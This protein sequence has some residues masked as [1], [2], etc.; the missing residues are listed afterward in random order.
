MTPLAHAYARQLTLPLSERDSEVDW[1]E[2]SRRI[3]GM[4][5]F[6]ITAAKGAWSD[7]SQS[8]Q[9]YIL[10]EKQLPAS[11]LFFLPA[12]KTWIEWKRDDGLRVAALLVEQSQDSDGIIW[13]DIFYAAGNLS[14]DKIDTWPPETLAS[15]WIPARL[16]LRGSKPETFIAAENN[17]ASDWIE[18]S[19]F[20]ADDIGWWIEVFAMLVIIN[21]PRSFGQVERAPH[22]GLQRQ[23]ARAG[24]PWALHAWHEIVLETPAAPEKHSGHS[25]DGTAKMP[26]HFVRKYIKWSTGTTVE[27]HYR[28][29]A[30]LGIKRGRYRIVS[31]R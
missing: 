25:E 11:T 23:L 27:S 20:G 29:D 16:P 19:P 8:M 13:A 9:D 10:R 12:P 21:E 7:V 4:K 5:C 18:S 15:H 22:R 31:D 2:L 6:E 17:P 3:D 26:L 28:G 24:I 14:R 30:S 1:R